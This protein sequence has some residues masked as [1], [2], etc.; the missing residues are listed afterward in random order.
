MNDRIEELR[1]LIDEHNYRYHV[2]DDP[3]ISDAEYDKLFQALKALESLHPEYQRADSPTQK[4]GAAP[5]AKFSSVKHQQ[6]MLSLDNAFSEEAVLAFYKRMQDRLKSDAPIAMVC[7]PKLDGLAINLRYEQGVLVQAATRGDGDTGED[8]TENV[9]TIKDIPHRLNT[10]TP[11]ASIEIRGEAYMS[12][13]AFA[14]LNAHALQ[15]GSKSFANPRN[16]AAGSIRQLDA[17][18]TADRH[19]SFYAYGVGACVEGNIAPTH[20]DTLMQLRSWGMPVNERVAIAKSTDELIRYHQDTEKARPSLDYDI[21]GVVYKANDLAVQQTL[22]YIARAP[23][24]AIAH[25]F[26]AQEE[27]TTVLA[28]DFQV[29]RTGALTPVARLNPVFVGGVTVSNATLHNMDEIAR[30]GIC[31]GDTVVIRRAGDVIPEIV[32]VVLSSRPAGALAIE[33]PKSCP[34]CGSEIFRAP[35]EAVARCTGGLVCTAQ[36]KEAL[37]HF[38]SRKAMDIEGMGDK[39][40][41]TLVDL[42]LIHDPADL[43]GLTLE[44]LAGLDRMGE[45]SA[46]N[47]MNALNASKSTTLARFIY[48]LGIREVG[49]QTAKLLAQHFKTF[50]ALSAANE[51]DLLEVTDVGPVVAKHCHH[52]LHEPHNMAVITKLRVAGITWPAIEN[53]PLGEQPL[54]GK[55]FVITGTMQKYSRDEAKALLEKLGAKVSGSVSAQTDYLVAGEKAGSKLTKAQALGVPILD[56][57]AFIE[58]VLQ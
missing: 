22:G 9:K 33:M 31:I 56:E 12:K 17:Q 39:I 28:V 24:F 29:G 38:A 26:P 2:M 16:A 18:I 10:Q 45:K 7:E 50:E 4:V 52:F 47:I 34:V 36:R 44:T 48:A 13:H 57:A 1:R 21:D 42:Q 49:E 20:Y 35:E 3:I 54:L 53:K 30:K 15:T 32:A 58:M 14:T 11:P 46:L 23:R 55:T 5:Q 27:N 51:S 19:L 6:A 25:K 40:I 37:K 41:E 43:Y 8:I